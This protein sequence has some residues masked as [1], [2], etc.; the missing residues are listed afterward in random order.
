MHS[1]ETAFWNLLI[2]STYL[3]IE[4]V[5]SLNLHF[6]TLEK[7][8]FVNS[9]KEIELKS[10]VRALDELYLIDLSLEKLN[11]HPKFSFVFD[12]C[13]CIHFFFN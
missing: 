13:F 6:L 11:D 3:Y 9:L 4:S 7:P 8:I 5:E 1:I 12:T 10:T 2:S